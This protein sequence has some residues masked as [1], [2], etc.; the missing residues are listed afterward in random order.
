VEEEAP[1]V[2]FS[3][4]LEAW[5]ATDGTKTIGSLG[6]VFGP[7][8]FA[9]IIL[10]LM[11]LPATPLPTGGITHVFEVVAA[12]VAVQMALGRHSLWLPERWSQRELGASITDKAVPWITRFVRRF[13]RWSRPR[14]VRWFRLQVVRQLLGLVLLTFIAFTLVAPPFS[15]LDTLPA[16]GAVVVS[17]AILL[18]DAVV[19]GVGL[20]LGVGGAVLIV[21]IGKAVV[22]FVS[23]LF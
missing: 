3:D 1:P 5:A 13:E 18:E 14:G 21:T 6:Q 9:V 10:L 20:A 11:A 15:G 2:R 17:L 23:G 16:L 22:H 8:G 4:E 19:L 12:L 7:R